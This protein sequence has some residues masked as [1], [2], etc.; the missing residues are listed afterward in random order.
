MMD[1]FTGVLNA[2]TGPWSWS[3]IASSNRPGKTP[4]W[5]SIKENTSNHTNT[6]KQNLKKKSFNWILLSKPVG[7]LRIGKKKLTSINIVAMTIWFKN[8]FLSL[9]VFRGLGQPSATSLVTGGWRATDDLRPV[10]ILNGCCASSS[11]WKRSTRSVYLISSHLIFFAAG[12][13]TPSTTL[14]LIKSTL[15][16]VST[17]LLLQCITMVVPI[18]I[19]LDVFCSQMHRMWWW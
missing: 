4:R 2:G 14:S 3:Q 9:I 8:P 12:A 16:A 1:P 15:I 17:E 6:R 19:K 18:S 13:A 11:Q 5:S 10:R 7:L